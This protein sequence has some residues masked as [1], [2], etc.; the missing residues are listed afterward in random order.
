MAVIPPAS[1]NLLFRRIVDKATPTTSLYDA[2]LITTTASTSPPT[3]TFALAFGAPQ[4]TQAQCL[5]FPSQR[6]AWQCDFAFGNDVAI[7][8]YSPLGTEQTGAELYA[9]GQPASGSGLTYGNQANLMSSTWSPFI[10]VID[11]DNSERGP[12]FYFQSSYD[13][14]VVIPGYAINAS[15]S[16]LK[17]DTFQ[18]PPKWFANKQLAAPGEKPW[19]CYWNST[20]LEGFIYTN[21][22]AQ[23]FSSITSSLATWTHRPSTTAA[24]STGIPSYPTPSAAPG[25]TITT[26]VTVSSTAHT[27]TGAAS[28][29]P[30][31]FQS[32]Y[33][34][35]NGTDEYGSH[36][37][38]RD[39]GGWMYGP[40][41]GLP[42]YP[43]M[44]KIEE[45][46]VPGSPQP[47]CVLY[48]IL[49]D[50]SYNWVPDDNGEQIIIHLSEHD[51]DANEYKHGSVTS[52]KRL[53][54][55]DD[56]LVPNGCHCQWLSGA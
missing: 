48:Q 14:V 33:P 24:T 55:R 8:I 46:R 54:K 16:K 15:V 30:S 13:K 26:T 5:T 10:Y 21:E 40:G 9:P 39:G 1:I 43:Y 34:D 27:F 51:P 44:V 31:W 6:S 19:M 53:A 42:I 56:E 12:A 17:R 7:N 20:F 35:W 52:G 38:K 37:S 47:F 4:E 2:S 23:P 32:T 11:N 41:P 50:G 36:Q 25:E 29:Y 45:R 28:A 22:H 18:I 3:G 49:N